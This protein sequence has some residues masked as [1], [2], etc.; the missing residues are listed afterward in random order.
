[1]MHVD[2]LSAGIINKSDTPQK[3]CLLLFFE[4]TKNMLK[5]ILVL[6]S[7]NVFVFVLLYYELII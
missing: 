3:V 5:I 2:G 7:L 6:V 4:H 1:M